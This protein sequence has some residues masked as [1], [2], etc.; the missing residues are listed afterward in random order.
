[1]IPWITGAFLGRI[2]LAKG[3]YVVVPIPQAFEW[4][5]S[6]VPV[7]I[8]K[9]TA[10]DTVLMRMLLAAFPLLRDDEKTLAE[11][12]KVAPMPAQGSSQ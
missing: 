1:L 4:I 10:L 5:Q 8:I 2:Y 11:L 9:P 7:A 3:E 6:L 12:A